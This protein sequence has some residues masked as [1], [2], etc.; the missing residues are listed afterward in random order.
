[1]NKVEA[2]YIQCEDCKFHYRPDDVIPCDPDI[3]YG[4]ICRTCAHY[5]WLKIVRSMRIENN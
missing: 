4:Y 5:V 1:M 2:I 3:S